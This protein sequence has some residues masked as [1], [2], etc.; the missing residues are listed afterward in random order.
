MHQLLANITSSIL[1]RDKIMAGKHVEG[2]FVGRPQ[3]W[4]FTKNPFGEPRPLIG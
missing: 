3:T 1:V 2:F 4:A